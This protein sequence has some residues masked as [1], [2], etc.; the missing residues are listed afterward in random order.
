V[1]RGRI[2]PA[3]FSR[4]EWRERLQARGLCID[5]MEPALKP[6][7]RCARHLE[8]VRAAREKHWRKKGSQ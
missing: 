4:N 6:N 5:C 1:T 2:N 3:S 8:Q 7:K